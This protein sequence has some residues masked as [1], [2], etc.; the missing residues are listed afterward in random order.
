[1]SLPGKGMSLF[2]ELLKLLADVVTLCCQPLTSLFIVH[3]C[4]ATR[5]QHLLACMFIEAEAD[6]YSHMDVSDGMGSNP[7]AHSERYCASGSPV[8]C[9]DAKSMQAT[10]CVLTNNHT[11]ST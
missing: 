9:S 10:D 3:R 1:M 2:A 5:L 6:S 7:P 4:F 11:T 8:R